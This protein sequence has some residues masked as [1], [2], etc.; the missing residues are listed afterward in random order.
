VED[1]LENVTQELFDL[2]VEHESTMN[3]FDLL[4]A[5]YEEACALWP[6]STTLL[7]K[8]VTRIPAIQS[9]RYLLRISKT[10]IFFSRREGERAKGRR[11]IF[12]LAIALIGIVLSWGIAQ[13]HG[14]I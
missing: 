3:E 7:M 10:H 9:C 4:S 2:K 13:Y 5:K 12:I 14:N 6:N 1:K 11:T 8:H